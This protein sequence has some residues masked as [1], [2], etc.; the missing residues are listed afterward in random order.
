MLTD[1]SRKYLNALVLLATAL[2]TVTVSPRGSIDP[3][4]L[5]KLCILIALGSSV[6]G[7]LAANGKSLISSIYRAPILLSCIF[8]VQLVAVFLF[9]DRDLGLKSYGIFG[10]NTGF[11]AYLF[12][13]VIFLAGV[14][15]A[16]QQ[17]SKALALTFIG[18]GCSLAIYGFFQKLGYDF[19]QFQNLYATN[20]FGTL[21]NPN[22]HSAL[23]GMAAAVLLIYGLFSSLLLAQKC[24]L[25]LFAVL[26]LCNVMWSS[27]QGYLVFFASFAVALLMYL[28]MT[29]KLLL[30][31]VAL[32]ATTLGGICVG[33][34]LFNV[35][36]AS[37]LVYGSSIEVR[38][39][40]WRAA[41]NLITENPWLGS[42]FDSYGDWYR[43]GRT[44]E[45]AD[46]NM[47]IAADSAHN[48]PL[49]IGV[50]GGVP[51]L[52]AYIAIQ[53]LVLISIIKIVRKS[54]SFEVNTTILIA[55]WTGFQVQS[56]ISINSLGVGIWGWISSGAII[57]YLLNTQSVSEKPKQIGNGKS[58]RSRSPKESKLI[59]IVVLSGLLGSV[60]ALAPYRA[61]NSFLTALKTQNV[62]VIISAASIKPYDRYRF[63]YVAD[64]L[65]QNE[66]NNEALEILKQGV[67]IFPDSL[68]IWRLIYV[69]PETPENVIAKAKTELNR[70][71][72]RNPEWR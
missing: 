8:L 2:T 70:L 23:M 68:E 9:D 25:L 72:P 4:N 3:I 65:I 63:L 53:A 40:Y 49:D 46:Y 28:F 19:Y 17:F 20:V 35:G 1:T 62:E 26:A 18:L 60:I 43:R 36:P 66:K 22:F 21:G 48:I 71:D 31:W 55:I 14:F 47:G 41:I 57:G 34:A 39:F 54:T 37:R 38:G 42:G 64:I 5:P 50:N 11:L 56:L 61:A 67:E 44:Q 29:R 52:L 15:L 69:N 32:A 51:L 12:L 7:L 33:L 6:V 30:A 58:T 13:A 10:R 24:I 45:I 59:T 27:E 16:S